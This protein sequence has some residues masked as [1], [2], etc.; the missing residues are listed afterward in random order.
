MRFSVACY[1]GA[2]TDPIRTNVEWQCHSIDFVVGRMMV[3][4]SKYLRRCRG[5]VV[6][7]KWTVDRREQKLQ[8]HPIFEMKRQWLV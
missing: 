4:I 5:T 7:L 3:A 2:G 1:C 6:R 8:P